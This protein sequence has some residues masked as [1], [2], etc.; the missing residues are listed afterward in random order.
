MNNNDP[1]VAD[2]IAIYTAASSAWLDRATALMQHSDAF[3]VA[4][5]I[6]QFRT[7]EAL[8]NRLERG[9]LYI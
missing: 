8:R 7:A 3:A 9:L 5:A 6:K 2:L 1:M 4:A